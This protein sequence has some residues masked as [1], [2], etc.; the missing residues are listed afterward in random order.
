MNG[1]LTESQSAL[2]DAYSYFMRSFSGLG[3]ALETWLRER[4]EK[5]IGESL[6]PAALPRF[7]GPGSLLRELADS[8]RELV[9]VRPFMIRSGFLRENMSIE[10]YEGQA[11]T[12]L[13]RVEPFMSVILRYQ[14]EGFCVPPVWTAERAAAALGKSAELLATEKEAQLKIQRQEQARRI[15]NNLAHLKPKGRV[16]TFADLPLE[17]ALGERWLC[18]DTGRG[19]FWDGTAWVDAGVVEQPVWNVG[20]NARP[21]KRTRAR[22]LWM[23]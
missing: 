10:F 3:A 2:K 7:T 11:R 14:S 1:R 15:N 23:L 13:L 22:T 21:T 6:D 12:V 17:A 18:K 5:Q 9:A 4:I 8:S 20:Y 16:L 19:Y